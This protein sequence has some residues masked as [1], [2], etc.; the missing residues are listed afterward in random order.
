MNNQPAARAAVAP[1]TVPQ[2]TTGGQ[3]TLAKNTQPQANAVV[4]PK[5]D[6][7]SREA[8]IERIRQRERR[9]RSGQDAGPLSSIF[10]LDDLLPIGTVSGGEG[11][12]EVMFFSKAVN[13]TISFPV[14]SRF[15]DGWLVGYRPDGVELNPYGQNTT[16]SKPWGKE[17]KPNQMSDFSLIVPTDKTPE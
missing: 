12:E 17:A 6:L 3:E 4:A 14:G 1:K 16:Y 8:T 15:F 10:A 9:L 5:V 2:K 7:A 13:Q 11:Q